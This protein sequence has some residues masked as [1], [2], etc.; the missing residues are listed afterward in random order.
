M[1]VEGPYGRLTGEQRVGSK[2]A[3]IACGIGITPMRALLEDLDYAPGDAILV[4]R[5]RSEPDLVFRAELERLAKKRGITLYYLLGP[6]SERRGSW[7]PQ[8]VGNVSDVAA[9]KRV[10]P[11]LAA[12]D[13]FV[14]G[15]DAWMD[16][17]ADAALSAGLP[18]AQLHQER[19]SW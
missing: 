7:L 16:A 2:V 4:Y 19:F 15:P 14:C 9:I 13:V 11:G 17:V 5:A 6:R 10:I 3:M 1:L 12:Y 18:P 8:S